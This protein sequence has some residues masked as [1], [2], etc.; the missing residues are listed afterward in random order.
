M[1]K[2][3]VAHICVLGDPAYYGRFGYDVELAQGFDTPYPPEF[4]A[5][6][7]FHEA[8]FRSLAREL[9]YPPAF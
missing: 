9:V 2:A 7:V 5:A 4:T 3:G 1:E 6:R 8:A